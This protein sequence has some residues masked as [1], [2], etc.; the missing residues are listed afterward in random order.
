MSLQKAEKNRIVYLDIIRII[1]C[2]LVILVHVTAQHIFDESLS[3]S[4]FIIY[5]AYNCIAYSGVSL[6]IMISGALIISSEKNNSLKYYISKVFHFYFLYFLWKGIYCIYKAFK[7]SVTIDKAFIRD[8]AIEIISGRGYYHLWFLPTIAIL[9]L[10]APIIKKAMQNEK[11]LCMY[12][13]SIFFI[14]SI[15]IETLLMFRIKY[16][17]LLEGFLTYNDFYLFTGY[18]G[19]FVLGYYLYKYGDSIKKSLRTVIYV[20]GIIS[21]PLSGF[22]NLYIS[23]VEDKKQLLLNNPFSLPSFIMT[24]AIF[25][26]IKNMKIS[27]KITS[28]EKAIKI[29]SLCSIMTFGIYL[30]HPVIVDV[31]EMIGLTSLTEVSLVLLPLVTLIVLLL[32]A[33]IVAILIN[34][35]IIKKSIT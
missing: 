33:G 34:I 15:F 25:L 12:F 26:A 23:N 9:Y 35:P 31:I 24:C 2:F 1:A 10:F 11:K 3:N 5:A 14:F 19:Y 22:L 32:T 17:Q 16:K 13:I 18:I 29:I 27:S 7:L 21:L 20:L 8:T 6:Y 4:S 28:N 30:I